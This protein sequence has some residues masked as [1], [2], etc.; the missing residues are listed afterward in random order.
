MTVKRKITWACL[1]VL[2]VLIEIIGFFPAVVEKYY[3]R[4]LYPVI[5]RTQRLLFGWIPFSVGDLLYLAAMIL[6]IWRSILFIR[7]VRRRQ[8]AKGWWWRR[9]P[10]Q[11]VFLLLWVYVLFKLLWGLNYDR[12]G[13]P[14]QFH[15]DVG[16]YVR[17]YDN[18]D[19]QDLMGIITHEVLVLH[20]RAAA[21]RGSLAHFARL[22]SGAIEAYDSL[23]NRDDDLAYRTPSVKPS[24]FSWPGL[25]IGFAGYYN[26]FS[27]EAQVDVLDPVFTLPYTTCHEMGHQLGYAKEN[28]ANFAG[29]LAAR[30]SPDPSFQYSVYLDL[31]MYAARELYLRDSTLLQP[32]RQHLPPGVREDIRAIQQFNRRYANPIAPFIWK[33]YGHYLRANRQPQGIVTYSEVLA[34]L[35]AYRKRLGPEAIEPTPQHRIP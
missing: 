11:M 22:R 9:L 1:I 35:I 31:Y 34:W 4:G 15:L 32:Y 16:P 33:A 13:I 18:A 3:S 12:L 10:A 24:L 5:S 14:D 19:L 21:S 26:P 17:P 7:R 27:G 20:D 30:N 29:F 25:Y 28:E 8:L 6:I 2:A 23:A